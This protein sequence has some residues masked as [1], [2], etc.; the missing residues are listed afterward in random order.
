LARRAKEED[1]INNERQIFDI[2]WSDL[3]HFHFFILKIKQNKSEPS[4]RR[5]A[6]KV[7]TEE[8]PQ[9]PRRLKAFGQ[10]L[11]RRIILLF[12]LCIAAFPVK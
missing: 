8:I 5:L 2:I 1:R 10:R 9:D 6:Y 7:P 12:I 3:F 4:F 11:L